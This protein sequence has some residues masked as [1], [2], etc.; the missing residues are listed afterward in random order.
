VLHVVVVDQLAIGSP[1]LL[2]EVE[3]GG[4]DVVVGRHGLCAVSGV[5]EGRGAK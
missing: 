4:G 5:E 2:E 1:G 3:G